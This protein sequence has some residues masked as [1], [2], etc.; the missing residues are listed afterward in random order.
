MC[1]GV[2]GSQEEPGNEEMNL[3]TAISLPRR[4]SFWKQII[5]L[6]FGHS[7]SISNQVEGQQ[8]SYVCT[9]DN[10]EIEFDL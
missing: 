8:G 5:C 2:S 3:D 4:G 10:C 6:F 7:F 9:C 1:V